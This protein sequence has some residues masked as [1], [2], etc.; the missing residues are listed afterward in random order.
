[1]FQ[2]LLTLIFQVIFTTVLR[3]NTSIVSKIILLILM[4][5]Y[6]GDLS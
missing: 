1:M 2:Y 3:Y 4:A 5:M 6:T